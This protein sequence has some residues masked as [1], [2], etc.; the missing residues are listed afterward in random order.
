MDNNPF[1]KRTHTMKEEITIE[2]MSTQDKYEYLIGMIEGCM[3]EDKDVVH[4]EQLLEALLVD[5]INKYPVFS[6][7]DSRVH[8]FEYPTCECLEQI[9]GAKSSRE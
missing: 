8:F 6:P 9:T 3:T 7:T 4:T 2:S 5:L 1:L